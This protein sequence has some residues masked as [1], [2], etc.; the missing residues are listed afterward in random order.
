MLNRTIAPASK[1]VTH[2]NLPEAEK[3]ILANGTPVFAVSA[4]RSPVMSIDLYFDAGSRRDTLPGVS[5]LTL[6]MLQ[7]GTKSRS[8]KELSDAI[9]FFGAY[10]EPGHNADR[11]HIS[12]HCLTRFLP[13]LLP[14]L[15]EMVTE[16][17]FPEQELE[18]QKNILAQNLRVS[19]AR[20][21]Y[22]ASSGF[23]AALYGNKHP[24][25]HTLAEEHLEALTQESLSGFF[26][27]YILNT[28]LEIIVAGS[29]GDTEYLLIDKTF[30]TMTRRASPEPK[31]LKDLFSPS[32]SQLIVK[33]EAKQSS[34]RL[35]RV[36]FNRRHPDYFTFKMLNEILGG[37]FG[38]RL[39]KNIRE[40]K[41][42]SYGIYSQ[43]VPLEKSGYFVIGTDVSIENTSDAL[44]EIR[45]EIKLLQTVPVTKEELETVRNYMLGT[46]ATSLNTPFALADRFKSIHFENLDYSYYKNMVSTFLTIKPSQIMEAAQKY[47]RED[48]LKQVV[49][50]ALQTGN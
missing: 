13:Q 42:Y 49:V 5:F 19:K 6:K 35:G 27:K 10:H 43:V 40:D 14:V 25:G 24:Y 46:F 8:A 33:E 9:A 50:G 11:I 20:N 36:L 41:G 21:S 1:P 28:S 3:I 44:S 32:G 23:R 17:L 18:T 30:G 31:P 4:G 38:S 22:L 7:E 29:V 39:M 26:D 2:I 15:K 48:D 16:P 37:Y 12:L 34:I 47:L 45:K